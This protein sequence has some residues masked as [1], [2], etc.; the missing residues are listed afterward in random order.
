MG[1]N[2]GKTE[3]ENR[4]AKIHT[5]LLL[6]FIMVFITVT[7]SP[8]STAKCITSSEGQTTCK[9][10]T[11]KVHQFVKTNGHYF[12]NSFNAKF[13]PDTNMIYIGATISNIEENPYYRDVN[14]YSGDYQYH[15]KGYYFN[16]N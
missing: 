6:V 1:N 5:R 4:K 9:L 7:F 8:N 12:K 13:N 14:H 16:I 3:M 2:L 11:I 15:S 10:I